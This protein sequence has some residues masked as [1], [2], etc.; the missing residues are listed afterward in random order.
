MLPALRGGD[1][2][3]ETLWWEHVGNAAIQRGRW[4]LVR[5]Y[6]WPWELY[7]VSSDRSE[8]HDLAAEYPD[9]VQDLAREWERLAERHGVIPFRTT[10]D[11]Y[12]RRGLGWNY[13]IG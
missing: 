2:G 11:I 13:A 5:Q 7:D 8:S 9:V 12:R 3:N 1:A 4:K 10:M 6:E